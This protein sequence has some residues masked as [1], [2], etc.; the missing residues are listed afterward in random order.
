MSINT[1]FPAGLLWIRPERGEIETAGN[2]T[3]V[4]EAEKYPGDL[5]NHDLHVEYYYVI[6]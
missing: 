4:A 2:Q 1:W 6:L 3:S 5:Q